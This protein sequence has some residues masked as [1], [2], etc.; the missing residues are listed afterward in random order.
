[1][2]IDDDRGRSVDLRADPTYRFTPA[3]PVSHF[4]IVVGSA[5]AV[6]ELLDDSVPKEFAMGNNFP[7]PFNPITTIPVTIPWESAVTLSVYTI[8]GEQVRMLHDGP[9]AA[10][11]HWIVWDG[12][13][14]Q[15]RSVSSGVY[16]IRMVNDGGQSFVRKM[17]MMK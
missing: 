2:L 4:R 3:A 11:R 1:V 12:T 16:F 5:D 17:V 8:L 6:R 10:G 13:N 7:N 9:L 14:D 15:G